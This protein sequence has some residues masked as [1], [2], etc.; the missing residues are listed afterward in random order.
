MHRMIVIQVSDSSDD[1][2]LAKVMAG[3]HG[4]GRGVHEHGEHGAGQKRHERDHGRGLGQKRLQ[5]VPG[6]LAHDERGQQPHHHK[7]REQPPQDAQ[8][9]I[10]LGPD[11]DEGVH[12]HHG[13]QNKRDHLQGQAQPCGAGLKVRGQ[14]RL[15]RGPAGAGGQ[16]LARPKSPVSSVKGVMRPIRG[17]PA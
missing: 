6:R 7:R 3:P 17:T 14:R 12:G 11:K 1:A 16:K 8:V 5:V 10:H 13:E 4:I 9:R 2:A 15:Q